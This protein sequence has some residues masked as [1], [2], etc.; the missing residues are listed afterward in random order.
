[1]MALQFEN[2]FN[3]ESVLRRPI[4]F[5]RWPAPKHWV[6]LNFLDLIF[7]NFSVERFLNLVETGHC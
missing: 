6:V 3:K 2:M 7:N 1:M 5:E 4:V